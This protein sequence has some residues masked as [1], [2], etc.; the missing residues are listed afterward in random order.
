VPRGVDAAWEFNELT[1]RT[2][3]LFGCAV[4][5]ALGC[6]AWYAHGSAA[7]ACDSN[8]TQGQVYRVLHEQ[9]HM[10]SVFLHDVSTTSGGYFSG[11]HDCAG[12]AAE[13][14]GNVDAAD[15]SWRQVHYRVVR[16]D[17]SED[18][19]VTVELGG[20]TPFVKQPEQTFW[21]RLRTFF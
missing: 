12:E 17:S 2:T 19:D 8:E 3:L 15:L 4:V 5:A 16:S 20:A 14:R 21:T 7:P 13:I 10:D 6:A 9:F 11:A 1:V 18:P